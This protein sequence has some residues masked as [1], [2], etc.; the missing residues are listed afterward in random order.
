MS[1]YTK[2]LFSPDGVGICWEG[3]RIQFAVSACSLAS[4]PAEPT[5]IH[6]IKFAGETIFD[7]AVHDD[8][9]FIL[10]GIPTGA[11]WKRKLKRRL[12]FSDDRWAKAHELY[13]Y[14]LRKFS[15]KNRM[16]TGR[17]LWLPDQGVNAVI[18]A[19]PG[20]AIVKLTG[21][22]CYVSMWNA[23]N[24][25]SGD[26]HCFHQELTW[27]PDLIAWEL[28]FQDAEEEIAYMETVNDDTPLSKKDEREH[29]LD[30]EILDYAFI[31]NS[32]VL[33]VRDEGQDRDEGWVQ[34]EEAM[35]PAV[36]RF[37]LLLLSNGAYQAFYRVSQLVS[38][39]SDCISPLV[40][41]KALDGFIDYAF[42]DLGPT[43][44]GTRALLPAVDV[45]STSITASAP[46]VRFVL[47][48]KDEDE[49]EHVD[50]PFLSLFAENPSDVPVAP[51]AEEDNAAGHPPYVLSWGGTSLV[52]ITYCNREQ[53]AREHQ[54]PPRYLE[55]IKPGIQ[56]RFEH[57]AIDGNFSPNPWIYCRKFGDE[58]IKDGS[59]RENWRSKKAS[60]GKDIIYGQNGLQDRGRS[61]KDKKNFKAPGGYRICS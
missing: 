27:N 10:T 11:Q 34:A 47:L 42:H 6:E 54:H 41:R 29:H 45:D 30:M 24:P 36:E 58:Q 39:G 18:R 53:I 31:S 15:I 2:V 61:K 40:L 33:R 8:S 57:P 51:Q 1:S 50:I 26:W 46:S 7:A 49:P 28:G 16:Q 12:S 59:V 48:G 25:H 52:S 32:F 17:T 38:P 37:S 44:F 5:I 3:T 60:E 35:T 56:R 20:A 43:F 19:G 22:A 4:F 14:G 9:L 55:Y 21:P 13:S 23:P